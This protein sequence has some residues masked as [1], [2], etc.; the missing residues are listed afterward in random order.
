[1]SCPAISHPGPLCTADLFSLSF[2][3][4]FFSRENSMLPMAINLLRSLRSKGAVHL[5][6][7]LLK[8]PALIL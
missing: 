1:V 4:S 8:R 7:R 3:M 2:V 5:M 6:D